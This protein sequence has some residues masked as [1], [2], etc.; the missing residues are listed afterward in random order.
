M[1]DLIINPRFR[2][3][4]RPLKPEEY[5][6]LEQNILSDGRVY[7]AIITWKNQIVDGHNR[8]LIIQ[9]HQEIPYTTQEMDFPDEWAVIAW[10]CYN[11]LGRR[12]LT[13]EERMDMLGRQSLAEK[14]SVGAP[15]GNQNNKSQSVQLGP[16]DNETVSR[17]AK[18]HGV[19]RSTVK[20]AEKFS[21]GVDAAEALQP[22]AKERILSGETKA[23]KSVIAAL[24]NMDAEQ[25]REVVEKL[26]SGEPWKKHKSETKKKEP[27]NEQ[28][29][30]VE[31]VQ[32][33]ADETAQGDVLEPE[34]EDVPETE[35]D[36]EAESMVG[37]P[38][39]E[40]VKILEDDL[41]N[42]ASR[43]QLVNRSAEFMSL[44]KK[45]R[46]GLI[47]EDMEVMRDENEAELFAAQNGEATPVLA[48]EKLRSEFNTGKPEVTDMVRACESVG[49]A[50]DFTTWNKAAYHIQA[51]KTI[52]DI[53]NKLGRGM[54]V[55]VLSIIKD[56][57]DGST[58]SLTREIISGMALF[59]ST[60]SGQFQRKRL[61]DK[62]R[63]VDPVSITREARSITSR[64][65]VGTARVILRTYNTN[66][67]RKTYIEGRI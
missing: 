44:P 37:R 54:L 38:V 15:D 39:G 5:D 8:W 10:I 31:T 66:A 1:P 35:P 49:M 48:Y 27:E 65:A 11:Q 28:E 64:G 46:L 29:D 14:K 62:L 59:C 50:V 21:K 9:K 26:M 63:K 55:S 30:V 22:G 23:P 53:Y 47:A 19:G 51:V 20:R 67:S 36:D 33:D 58:D 7:S 2:D 6:L 41:Q 4:T 3:V 56:A 61:V 16:I 60:Y 57:W 40:I 43:M 12:N 34:P 52:Y 25:Q 13:D 18:Q 24:P 32:D 17:I 42:D 45:E